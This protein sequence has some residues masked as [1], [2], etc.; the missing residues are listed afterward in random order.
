MKEICYAA[1]SEDFVELSKSIFEELEVKIDVH[2][3][4]SKTYDYY[5]KQGIKIILGRGKTA[6]KI[7]SA[8]DIPVIEIPISFEDIVMALDKAS[9]ISK[10]VGIVGYNNLIKNLSILNTIANIEIIQKF[11]LDE[12]DTRR[13]ILDLKEKGVKVIIGGIAQTRIAKENRL[14]GIRLDLTKESLKKAYLEAVS[15]IDSIKRSERKTKELNVILDNTREAYIS[16]DKNNKITLANKMALKFNNIS[17]DENIVGKNIEEVFPEFKDAIEK[18]TS[19][20]YE[21]EDI[22]TI[23]NREVIY[24]FINLRDKKEER[25]GSIIKINDVKHITDAEQ[26][27][28]GK[29]LD[30]GFAADYQ[31]E[32]IIG[33]SK[34]LLET[35]NL[36]KKFS[37]NSSTVLILGNS[38]TGKELFA[39]SIHNYSNRSNEPFVAINCGSLPENLLESELFGYE[40][41]AFT[42]ANRQGKEGLFEL[43]HKGTIFLDEISEMSLNLQA[44]FLRVLQEKKIIRLGGIKVIPIDI[45]VIAASNKDL[46]SLVLKKEFREDLFYRLNVLP[47]VVPD[48]KER[49]EDIILLTKFFWSKLSGKEFNITKNGLEVLTRYSWPGNVRQ[50]QN[51]IEKISIIN[52]SE[53]FTS[54]FIKESIIKYELV[55]KEDVQMFK[56]I[57]IDRE[58]I[59]ESLKF[60][61][62]NKTKAAQSLLINR[63]TLWR[64]LER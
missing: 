9:K 57:E 29:I 39:Q 36:A 17:L 60:F 53:L 5:E 47:I 16:I 19:N 54:N 30:K 44:R 33:C 52:D 6:E 41:G 24:N 7:R 14:Q 46:K 34:S 50:L 10:K 2:V 64:I 22:L 61:N 42:G 40:G 51:Y 43:S 37:K 38:G 35:K 13:I 8:L 62:N 23:N 28:R 3:W 49:K 15:I 45:R 1:Y 27:I 32:D 55:Y 18:N 56:E 58:E 21:R 48:L 20:Y 11:A 25:I 4:G 26:R 63:S 12:D 59:E 31:F